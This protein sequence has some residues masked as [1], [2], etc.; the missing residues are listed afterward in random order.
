MKAISYILIVALILI[1][2]ETS[3]FNR[4]DDLIKTMAKNTSITST[5]ISHQ[6]FTKSSFDC[7][8]YDG[9]YNSNVKDLKIAIF[10]LIILI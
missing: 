7:T 6:I 10:I 4:R 8:D 5:D 1:G 2:C 3:L 9:S